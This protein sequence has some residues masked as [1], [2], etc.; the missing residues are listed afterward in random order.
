MNKLLLEHEYMT[1]ISKSMIIISYYNYERSKIIE[2]VCNNKLTEVQIK[3]L[4]LSDSYGKSIR[5]GGELNNYIIKTRGKVFNDKETASFL[6][7]RIVELS[8]IEKRVNH[9]IGD[10]LI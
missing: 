1:L 9:F 10:K 8:D 2:Y 7:D 6:L 4:S 3:L 5:D